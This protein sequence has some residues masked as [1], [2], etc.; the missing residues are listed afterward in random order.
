MSETT[1]TAPE[2]LPHAQA[3]AARRPKGWLDNPWVL[4]VLSVAVLLGAWQLF[5]NK[6]STSFPTDVA[7]TFPHAFVHEVVPALGDTL[8][9]FG[10]GYTAC[11]LLGIPIGLLMARSRLVELALE[12]YVNALYA[13]PRL[14]LIPVLILWLG[15]NFQMRFAVVLISGLFPIILNTYLG[16]KEVDRNLLDAGKAFDAGELQTLRTIVIP[17]SLPY[18][19]AGLRLGLARSFIGI[20]V[21]EIETSVLGIG[22][23]IS[24][25]AQTLQFSQMW[26]A[27]ITLG[28]LS[29]LFSTV[30]KRTEAWMVTPWER[31]GR[32][33]WP[34]RA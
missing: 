16:A 15:I 12:P 9:G 33:P 8:K 30:L 6:Y 11:I 10:A 27:I 26:V 1:T 19:F 13:T 20:I 24:H 5:G 34:F 18:I 28:I 32:A 17:A 25:S 3:K 29:I 14:A 31:K 22:N 23:L 4:R 2:V 7:R 21:A